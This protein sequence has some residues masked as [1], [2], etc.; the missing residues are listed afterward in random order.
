M[1]MNEKVAFH[2]IL[3]TSITSWKSTTPSA[4]A[5]MA[6][7]HA[8]QPMDKF[9]GCQITSIRVSKKISDAN[10][11]DAND[12]TSNY[13]HVIRRPCSS[14]SFNLNSWLGRCFSKS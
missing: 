11:V 7:P 12:E 9:L 3:V 6:P 5:K 8:D 10:T 2:T 14:N 13:S 4:R 1:A